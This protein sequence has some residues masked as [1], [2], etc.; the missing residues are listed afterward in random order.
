MQTIF[1]Y[2][3]LAGIRLL[4]YEKKESHLHA[5]HNTRKTKSTGQQSVSK[6]CS[7]AFKGCLTAVLTDRHH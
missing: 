3:T 6:L 2:D 7:H 5:S 4:C 1:A